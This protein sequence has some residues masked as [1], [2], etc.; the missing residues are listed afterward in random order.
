MHLFFRNVLGRTIGD[1]NGERLAI[2]EFNETRR[3]RKISKIHG[4]Q[5]YVG[6]NVGRWVDQYYMAHMFDHG[7][8]GRYDGLIRQA[9]LDL[10]DAPS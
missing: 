10:G 9:A 3:E 4:L 6:S 8:Y 2:A 1:H 7:L 5:Y